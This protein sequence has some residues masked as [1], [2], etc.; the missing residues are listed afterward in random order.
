MPQSM[1]SQEAYEP[2]LIHSPASA[3][4]LISEHTGLH[5]CKNVSLKEIWEILWVSGSPVGSYTLHVFNKMYT[6]QCRTT[7]K[8][9]LWMINRHIVKV[10]HLLLFKWTT[11]HIC[12][13][14]WLIANKLPL[15]LFNRCAT[16]CLSLWNLCPCASKNSTESVFVLWYSMIERSQ[17]STQSLFALLTPR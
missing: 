9:H 4:L 7:N 1:A 11:L 12:G 6:I 14:S 3:W 5:S 15:T 10:S 16:F 2:L 13:I 17:R 8:T